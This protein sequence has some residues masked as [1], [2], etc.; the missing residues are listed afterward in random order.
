MEDNTNTVTSDNKTN[1][2]VDTGNIKNSNV[3]ITSVIEDNTGGISATRVLMLTWGI[4][5]FIIWG[6]ATVMSVIHGVYTGIPIPESVVTILLGVVGGKI[7]Q[8]PFEK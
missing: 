6:F 7:V 1:V 2:T 3:S 8:R 5:V 4:G